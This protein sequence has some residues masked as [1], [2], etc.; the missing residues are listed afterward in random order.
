METVL[1]IESLDKYLDGKQI[2]TS[3]NLEI[4]SGE[5]FWFLWPNWAGKTTTMKCILWLINPDNWEI[6]ILWEP[7][8]KNTKSLIGFMP[9]NTYLYKYL[10]WY[11]FL[12]FNWNF[13]NIPADIL[14]EKIDE[15]LE[16][17]GL[18]EAKNK[19]LAKYSKWMLQRIWLAQAIINDPKIVFLDEPMSGL[20][21]LW[22]KMVKDLILELKD[23]WTTVFFNTHILSDVESICDRFAIIHK[24]QIIAEDKVK[25]LKK[26]LEEFFIDKIQ[27]NSW[28]DYIEVK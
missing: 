17:V 16:K 6:K 15:L 21:P 2:L 11:E 19:L 23:S 28:E 3:V 7:L 13:F 10:T 22:R 5:V 9:E 26:P 18:K 4:K 27:E 1:S 24:W 14:D 25:K 12:K 8:N 20:D